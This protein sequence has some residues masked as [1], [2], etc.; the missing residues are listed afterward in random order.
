MKRRTIE[1]GN[2]LLSITIASNRDKETLIRCIK[3]IFEK[4][5]DPTRIEVL[6]RIDYE[7]NRSKDWIESVRMIYGG[8]HK[9][10]IRILEGPQLFGYC[11][12]TIFNAEMAAVCRGEFV[13]VYNDDITDITEHYDVKLE[14]YIG[15]IVLFGGI[16]PGGTH[17]WDFPIIHKLIYDITETMSLQCFGNYHWDLF[18]QHAPELVRS[19][20]ISCDHRPISNFGANSGLGLRC[21]DIEDPEYR[22]NKSLYFEN[23]EGTKEEHFVKHYI[24]KVKQYVSENKSY[25]LE[26][27]HESIS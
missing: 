15:K 22:L 11:S 14:P 19:L 6:V 12:A 24:A 3:Y 8:V 2:I 26:K 7:A 9:D 21:E 5:S 10:R 27:E 20:D 16:A 23:Q 18:D 13:M 1:H 25:Q 17:H 4:A